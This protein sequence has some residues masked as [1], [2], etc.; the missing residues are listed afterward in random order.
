[1]GAALESQRGLG[2][3]RMFA[4]HLETRAEQYVTCPAT[5]DALERLGA[6]FRGGWAALADALRGPHMD[7]QKLCALLL[8][9]WK[10]ADVE[11]ATGRT[12]DWWLERLG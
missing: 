2:I 9:A 7:S 4:A 10:P 6:E 11:R 3:C 1:M 8:E 5:F 12:R